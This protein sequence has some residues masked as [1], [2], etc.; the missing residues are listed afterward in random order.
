MHVEFDG[1]EPICN[2]S[3]HVSLCEEKTFASDHSRLV[4]ATWWLRRAIEE[5]SYYD[6][7]SHKC[8]S[9]VTNA[10]VLPSG[11][12]HM[13]LWSVRLPT[14]MCTEHDLSEKT[15]DCLNFSVSKLQDP[16]STR[17]RN[18]TETF[19]FNNSNVST[20]KLFVGLEK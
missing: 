20:K 3:L 7:H 10:N 12:W 8:E 2:H 17:L 15:L 1:V 16:K 5:R 11:W 19:E 6:H 14:A 4:P 13:R 9:Q 18:A